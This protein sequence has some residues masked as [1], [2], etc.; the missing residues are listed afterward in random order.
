MWAGDETQDEDAL[1]SASS[2][3][4]QMDFNAFTPEA[5]A[6]ASHTATGKRKRGSENTTSSTPIGNNRRNHTPTVPGVLRSGEMAFNK[7]TRGSLPAEKAFSVQIGW[8]LFRLSGA[9][10]MSDCESGLRRVVGMQSA[11]SHLLMLLE[12]RHISPPISKTR[13]ETMKRVRKDP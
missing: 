8:K 13:F 3:Q 7:T 5:I 10:L 12:R 4:P 6:V 11:R 1:P 9:S 2:D